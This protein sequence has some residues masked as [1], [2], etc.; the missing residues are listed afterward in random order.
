MKRNPMFIAHKEWLGA[1]SEP[2][3]L[4]VYLVWQSIEHFGIPWKSKGK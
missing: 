4:E 2:I 3:A 1:M